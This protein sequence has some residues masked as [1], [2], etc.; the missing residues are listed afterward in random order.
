MLLGMFKNN[1]SQHRSLIEMNSKTSIRMCT[2]T[3]KLDSR[4]CLTSKWQGTIAHTSSSN[5]QIC[6]AHKHAMP[7]A[8]PPLTTAGGIT[9]EEDNHS[10]IFRNQIQ[11]VQISCGRESSSPKNS[12][13]IT[14]LSLIKAEPSKRAAK[15]TNLALHPNLKTLDL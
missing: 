3:F 1:R 6:W 4:R 10:I 11:W 15:L 14:F 13:F 12:Q 5:P 8:S 9:W 7:A 2:T